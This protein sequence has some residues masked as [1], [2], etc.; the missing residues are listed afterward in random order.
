MKKILI[1][2]LLISNFCLSQGK[3]DGFYKGKNNGSVV[4]GLGFEDTKNYFAGTER[5]DISRSLFYTSIFG[6]YG[7]TDNLDINLSLPYLV[8]DDNANF[9]D[10]AVLLKYRLI[11]QSSSKGSLELSVATGISTNVVDYQIN[12]LNAI[13][14]Q[15]TIIET[16]GMF[17]YKWN[18][19]W[20]VTGQSG[21]S[22][23]FEETPSSLPATLKV[24]KATSNWYYDFYYD[25]QYSFGGIDYLGTPRPQNFKEFGV[26]FHKVGGSVYKPFSS[27]FGAYVNLS[28]VISGR[29]VFQGPGYGIGLV[30]NFKKN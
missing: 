5:T 19:G 30:Y 11:Q 16:K 13:G 23:K 20:F 2:L 21:F 29:N 24:G 18:S 28:Y 6:A 27:T 1:L 4:L 3:I 22:F 26:D 10:V 7:I 14:Q 17:H 25:F 9:Q 15:A 12:G 8:S